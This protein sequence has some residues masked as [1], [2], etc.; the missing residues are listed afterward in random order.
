MTKAVD[1]SANFLSSSFWGIVRGVAVH[2]L[3]YPL[4][5]VK[6]H[7]QVSNHSCGILKTVQT[8]RE[9]DGLGAFYQGIKV[10]LVKTSMKQAWCW[11]MITHIPPALKGWKIDESYHQVLTGGAIATVDAFVTN[12]L[13]KT[14]YDQI[15]RGNQKSFIFSAYKQ[16]FHGLMIYWAHRSVSWISFLVAQQY[17]RDQLKDEYPGQ[18]LTL[19]Q[20]IKIG[21]KV[22]ALVSI[23]IAPFDVA[24]TRKQVQNLSPKLLLSRKAISTL[25]R[26]WPVNIASLAIHN[27]ASVVLIDQL[28]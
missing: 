27:V 4:E 8:I 22:A 3:I 21:L 13:E 15:F 28:Q 25:Y 20:L 17:F 19:P 14:K 7:L 1:H 2:S 9:K 10:Q 12:P 24:N 11:P 6:S 5:V 18:K 23:A 16:G 26:G